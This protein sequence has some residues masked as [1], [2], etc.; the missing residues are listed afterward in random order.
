[1]TKHKPSPALLAAVLAVRPSERRAAIQVA[2]K[3]F[4]NALAKLTAW[5]DFNHSTHIELANQAA[6]AEVTYRFA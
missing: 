4:T 3:T 1:M 2:D 5:G 6:I